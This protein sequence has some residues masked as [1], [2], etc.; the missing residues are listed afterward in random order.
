[1]K[2]LAKHLASLGWGADIYTA[3]ST[4]PYADF[5]LLHVFNAFRPADLMVHIRRSRLPYVVSPIYVDYSQYERK[6]RTGLFGLLARTAT[7]HQL[8]YLKVIARRL[9]NGERIVSPEYVFRGQYASVRGVLQNARL[10]I[11]QS[12]HE[13]RR[14]ESDFNV[15]LPYHVAAYGITPEGIMAAKASPAVEFRDTV[16]CVARIE[17]RKNQLGLIRALKGTGLRLVIVGQP[18]PNHVSYAAQCRAEAGAEVEFI[19]QVPHERVLE[20]LSAARVHVLPSHFETCGLSTLE[21]AALGTRV[22]VG[23]RGDVRDYF[24][25]NAVYCDPDDTASIRQAVLTAYQTPPRIGFDQH[26][27][28]R[29]TWQAMARDTADAYDRVLALHS[30]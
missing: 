17:G 15:S 16:G 14:V 21:A 13:M 4:P 10:I 25:S 30:P 11:P 22:V 28:E 2:Q 3:D 20:I 24:G 29:F 19:G 9:R 23:D 6:H 1:M 8:E 27:L 18:S 5:D 7:P 12:E 26:V